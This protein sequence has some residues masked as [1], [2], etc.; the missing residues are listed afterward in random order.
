MPK[1]EPYVDEVLQIVKNSQTTIEAAKR[2]SNIVGEVV[3]WNSISC[4]IRRLRSKGLDVPPL[5]DLLGV[6]LVSFTSY[7]DDPDDIKIKL[8]KAKKGPD[9]VP[10]IVSL[11]WMPKKIAVIPDMHFPIQ[12]PFAIEAMIAYLRDFKPDYAVILGDALDCFCLSRHDK[13][14]EFLNELK[15]QLA[16]EMDEL[17]PLLYV[18]ADLVGG[19]NNITW[20]EGNHEARRNNIL[21]AHPGLV[22]MPSLK[23]KA[24][25]GI[26]EDIVW[27]EN[28]KVHKQRFR[29]GNM[30]FEHGDN[31]INSRGST[32]IANTMSQR[33]PWCNTFTGH[34]H[35]VDRKTRVAYWPDGRPETFV[36][37]SLG[38]LSK[39][40][41]HEHYTRLPNWTHGFGT[42][43]TWKDGE[44]DRFSFDQI[45]MVEYT[46]SRNGK[47][48]S[49]KKTQ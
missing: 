4:A 42:I 13:P 10:A 37:A 5:F 41:E 40:Q 46:F 23:A 14:A 3:S 16:G 36:T 29:I 1:W 47:L 21:Q 26:P 31:V 48:Y 20:I 27:V 2:C 25:F 24:F 6:D 19:F 35:C 33:R 11:D 9:T 49:G 30:F 38:H 12:D 34:W 44:K 17:M 15:F 18:L 43:E 8:P 32:H 22:T 7:E 45:E 28:N 39:V